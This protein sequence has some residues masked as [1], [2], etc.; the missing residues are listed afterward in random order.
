MAAATGNALRTI[1]PEI[2]QSDDDFLGRVVYRAGSE[3]GNMFDADLERPGGN[4]G[5]V[6]IRTV[7]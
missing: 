4:N 2:F 7:D 5:F 6:K 1:L 3:D